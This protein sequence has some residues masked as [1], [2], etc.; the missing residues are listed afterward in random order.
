MTRNL[1]ICASMAAVLLLAACLAQ[2]PK[3]LP[4]VGQESLDL[5]H[6][7][8]IASGGDFMAAAGTNGFVCMM[9]P[10]DAGKYCNSAKD[11]ES[12]CLARSHSCAP[13]KPLL[14]CNEILTENGSQVTQCVQ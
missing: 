7:Q 13:V 6:A 14:G 2:A 12:D 3:K 1:L 11:C 5:S 4:P 9:V 10:K 8:C